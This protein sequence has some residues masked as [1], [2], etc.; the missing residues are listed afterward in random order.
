MLSF[1]R[2]F[3]LKNHESKI[4]MRVLLLK[5]KYFFKFVKKPRNLTTL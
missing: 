5:L 4:M 1:Y 3:K 2:Y